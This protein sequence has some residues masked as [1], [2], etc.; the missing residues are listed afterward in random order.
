[1]VV[2]SYDVRGQ[3][4]RL[5][6]SADVRAER[7]LDHPMVEVALASAAAPTYFPAVELDGEGGEATVLVDGGVFASAPAM[8]AFVEGIRLARAR[9]VDER[10]VEVV[11][12]GTGSPPPRPEL[13]QRE[14]VGRSWFRLAQAI[15]EAAQTGQSSLNDDMLEVL[16]GERYWRFDAILDDDTMLAMDESDVDNLAALD[17]LGLELVARRIG[18]LHRLADRLT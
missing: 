2:T 5:F 13:T 10:Y 7:A 1:V 3:R 9:G 16:L 15:F 11:S 14:F 18:D 17:R 4:P 6:R 12:L 8:V